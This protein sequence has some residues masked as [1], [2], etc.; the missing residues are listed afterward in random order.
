[1]SSSAPQIARVNAR[2]RRPRPRTPDARRLAAVFGLEGGLTETLYDD[3]DVPL[4]PGCIT[5]ILGPSGAGK[6]VL[7]R[8][9]MRDCPGGLW[10]DAD[11]L[12][13]SDAPAISVLANTDHRGDP[14]ELADRMAMLARCG[15]AEP[16][17][18]ITP[19]GRL[20]AGQRYRL[21]LAR[22]LWRA[23]RRKGG[24]PVVVAADEFGASL[25]WPTGSVL[26]RQIRRLVSRYGLCLLA[27]THRWDLLDDLQPGRTIVKPLG[28]PPRDLASRPWLPPQW[29]AP[30]RWTIRRGNIHDYRTLGRFH[31]LTG[32]PAAHKR[33]YVIAAPRVH[34][35][36]GGPAA[37][38]VAVVSPPVLQVRARNIVT[39]GRYCRHPR[40]RSTAR[41]NREVETISRVIVHPIYRSQGLSVRLVRHILRTSPAPVVEALAVMGRFHPFFERAGMRA[42]HHDDLRYV[43]YY[44]RR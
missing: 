14:A 32:P 38:A 2:I 35:R 31:Y 10:L 23:Q 37:A 19:A 41:L 26:C 33:V 34:R 21:A 44:H 25:D 42:Y 11:S 9:V 18:L 39:E 29:Q 8:A 17:A 13:E 1:M 20:S 24:R 6:S 5:A 36:H 40:S 4:D 15:L 28:E 12:A 43:Y 27:A 30:S 16:A 22:V 7:L 3:F